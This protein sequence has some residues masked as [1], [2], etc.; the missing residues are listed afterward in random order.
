MTT[1]EPQPGRTVAEVVTDTVAALE[2]QRR[3]GGARGREQPQLV[4]REAPLGEQPKH[5][6]ADLAGGA[7]DADARHRPVPP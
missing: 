3:A 2:G 5:D 6:G 4:D 1:T 7:D